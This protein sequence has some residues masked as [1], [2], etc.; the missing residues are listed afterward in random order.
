MDQYLD[1]FY[2]N[3]SSEELEEIENETEQEFECKYLDKIYKI[4]EIIE[5]YCKENA[6][7]IY[8]RTN[9]DGELYEFIINN[10]TAFDKLFIKNLREEYNLEQE[11]INS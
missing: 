3:L 1:N 6:L 2:N 9:L 11:E 10:S 7:E 4:Y 5:E 8:D